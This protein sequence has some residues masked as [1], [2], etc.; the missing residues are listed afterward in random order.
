MEQYRNSRVEE[1][2]RA[3][4]S[5]DGMAKSMKISKL[6]VAGSNSSFVALM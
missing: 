5:T 4:G 1:M 6:F 2:G 3:D